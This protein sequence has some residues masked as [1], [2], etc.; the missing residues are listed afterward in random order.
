MIEKQGK[1]GGFCSSSRKTR[2]GAIRALVPSLMAGA[3][4]V[5]STGCAPV[6][7]AVKDVLVGEG[8]PSL[9]SPEI[10]T[11]IVDLSGSTYPIQQLKA[12]GSGIEEYVSGA[13]LGNPF[14]S[15]K[16]PPKSLS[17]Q[18]IT[19]NSANASRISLVSAGTGVE[20]YNW[21]LEKSPNI[22]QAKPLWA[23]FMEART[24]LAQVH[25]E[26]INACEN[27]AI[28]I[29]GQQA[30]TGEVLRRPAR[31]ICSDI[32]KTQNALEQLSDFVVNPNVPLGS[33]VYGAIGLAVS[34]LKRADMQFP[35]AQKTLVIA[36]DLIDQSGDR[37]FVRKIK[38][39]DDLCKVA[40]DDLTNEY[41]NSL[42]FQDMFVVLVGQANSKADIDLLN[43]VRK[44]WTCYF[45]SAGA[46]L[47]QTT[48]LNNY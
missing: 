46:E 20:L 45:Q 23:G 43:K 1:E 27:E 42:P 25:Q 22:D 2:P 8:F 12:L 32:Y 38:A 18:F 17:I 3:L 13:S 4:M 14:R 33:D 47:I 24:R 40:K 39:G 6:T 41:G 31:L 29:F 35:M 36:S 10:A 34:N 15:P 19:Q 28:Q 7:S 5:T 44:Y 11:Y 9:P 37:A 26:D 48:D 21:M 16:L 30:L